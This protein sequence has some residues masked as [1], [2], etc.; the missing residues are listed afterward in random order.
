MALRRQVETACLVEEWN[1]TASLT[2]INTH[3]RVGLDSLYMYVVHHTVQTAN[4]R[5]QTHSVCYNVHARC[6]NEAMLLGMGMVSLG[7]Y[8]CCMARC[9][10]MTTRNAWIQ[11]QASM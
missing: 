11:T 9:G 3:L 7:L 8:I 10:T 6:M 2:V 5:K 1:A 4:I